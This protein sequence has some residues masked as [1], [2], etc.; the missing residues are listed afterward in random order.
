[1]TALIGRDLILAWRVGGSALTGVLFFLGTVA[2]MPF[3]IGPDLPLIERIGPAILWLG[4]LLASLLGL[5]R[6]VA[7]D[8]EDGSLDLLRLAPSPLEVLCL[9]KIIA[10]WLATGLPLVLAALPLGLLANQP[11]ESLLATAFTLLI[12]TPALAAWGAMGAAL[13]VAL[14]RGGLLTAVIVLPLCVPTLIFGT[15]S[16]A[17]LS[18][19][20]AGDGVNEGM[21]AMLQEASVPLALLAALSLLALAVAP[22]AMAAALRSEG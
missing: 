1:M 3:A 19:A 7:L 20:R 4:A 21:L 22:F 6:I 15:A 12:G 13:A 11:P 2:L 17:P 8:R 9:A 18:S 10:H 5:D 14:P 16:A